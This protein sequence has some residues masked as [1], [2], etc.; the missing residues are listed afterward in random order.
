MAIDFQKQQ[1]NIL[2]ELPASMK[3][4]IVI[5]IAICIEGL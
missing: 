3:P 1:K 5:Y 4:I 2:T